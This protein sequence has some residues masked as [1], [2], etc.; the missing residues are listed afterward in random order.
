M[1]DFRLTLRCKLHLRSNYKHMLHKLQEDGI[2]QPFPMYF[3]EFLSKILF[4]WFPT[5]LLYSR[6]FTS[7]KFDNYS[8]LFFFPHGLPYNS[9][10]P[11]HHIYIYLL[12]TR[13]II[14]YFQKSHAIFIAPPH[15]VNNLYYFPF[16]CFQNLQYNFQTTPTLR[17]H[18]LQAYLSLCALC[19]PPFTNP[20]ISPI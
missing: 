5:Y 4:I 14:Q 18:H 13:S 6:D 10:I 8:L 20:P 12:F 16:N 19:M 2:S 9:L 3:R 17:K 7:L 15:Y 11:K 1:R